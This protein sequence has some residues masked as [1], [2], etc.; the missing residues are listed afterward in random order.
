[1]ILLFFRYADTCIQFIDPVDVTDEFFKIECFLKSAASDNSIYT[2]YH[3]FI[4][5]RNNTI[6]VHPYNDPLIKNSV[7]VIALGLDT[8][9]R[10]NL[11]RQMPLTAE[12]IKTRLHGV[13]LLGY[14]KVADNT[15][16]NVI[17]VLTGHFHEELTKSC[18]PTGQSVFD[19]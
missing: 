17:P 13:D 8:V 7:S 16:P 1:M 3:A 19:N 10:L 18:W 6:N 15:F 14:N 2:D 5:V 12:F 4:P 11:H 9:S